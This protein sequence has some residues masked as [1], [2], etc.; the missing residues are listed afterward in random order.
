MPCVS[1]VMRSLLGAN[2]QHMRTGAGY[3]MSA[4]LEYGRGHTLEGTKGP[5]GV[6]NACVVEAP[7][8]AEGQETQGEQEDELGAVDEQTAEVEEQAEEHGATDAGPCSRGTL[9]DGEGVQGG[10]AGGGHARRGR[11]GKERDIT[12]TYAVPPPCRHAPTLCPSSSPRTTTGGPATSPSSPPYPA[13]GS[14]TPASASTHAPPS[15]RSAPRR[16]SHGRYP[17]THPS[18]L[19]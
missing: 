1:N 13:P 3:I 6:S 8:P 2:Q 10:G 15:T 18:L 7:R 4:T 16:F 9:A 19:S 14:S 17:R 12:P 11:R 5:L